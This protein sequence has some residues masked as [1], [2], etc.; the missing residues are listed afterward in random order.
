M[1]THSSRE[2]WDGHETEPSRS[3][4]P[5]MIRMRIEL[6]GNFSSFQSMPTDSSHPLTALVR[7]LFQPTN[8]E[9]TAFVRDTYSDED[10]E[11]M[12][13]QR[14]KWATISLLVVS[15]FLFGPR[16]ACSSGSASVQTRELPEPSTSTSDSTRAPFS[17]EPTRSPTMP[18]YGSG[19]DSWTPSPS[20]N[21]DCPAG[22]P[23]RRWVHL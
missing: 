2:P 9:P 6:S 13:L 15:L 8:W 14:G 10:S 7:R 4:E 17:T 19:K 20:T 21:S 22:S 11:R 16:M 1:P 5:G 3:S 18:K 12:Y 23:C